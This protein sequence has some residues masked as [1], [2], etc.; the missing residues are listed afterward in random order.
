MSPSCLMRLRKTTHK[1]ALFH[2]VVRSH[3]HE[4][5]RTRSSTV[6][7]VLTREWLVCAAEIDSAG[8]QDARRCGQCRRF[9]NTMRCKRKYVFKGGHRCGTCYKKEQDEQA[10]A[11]AAVTAVERGAMQTPE[12]K[13]RAPSVPI[14][15][16]TPEQRKALHTLQATE[17][18]QR[19][20]TVSAAGKA[21]VVS[22]LEYE[23]ESGSPCKR[24]RMSYDATLKHVARREHISPQQIRQWHKLAASDGDMETAPVQRI[25]RADRRHMLY[26]V[27]G[28]RLEVEQFIFKWIAEAQEEGSYTSVSLLRAELKRHMEIEVPRETLRARHADRLWQAKAVSAAH[29]VHQ[30][31]HPSLPRRLRPAAAAGE[32]WRDCAGVDG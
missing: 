24:A 13:R 3:P 5:S 7:D 6:D 22:A 8:L 21:R 19:G 2:A 23:L 26:S 28:P 11:A 17:S 25:T 4:S 27:L 14:P 20:R 30:L 1:K 29:R 9:W 31:P 18:G 32:G 16:C 10:H 12:K 15:S